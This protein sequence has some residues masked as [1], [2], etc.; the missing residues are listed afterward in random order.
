[1]QPTTNFSMTVTRPRFRELI[2]PLLDA[3][4]FSA[5]QVFSCTFDGG[6]FTLVLFQLDEHG[7]RILATTAVRSG[8]GH[9]RVITSGYAKVTVSIPI[10]T[11]L[12]S[13]FPEEIR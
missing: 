4:G 5:E 6:G 12:I 11:D 8:D 2:D 7:A 13:A 1:M 9:D 3:L 10:D